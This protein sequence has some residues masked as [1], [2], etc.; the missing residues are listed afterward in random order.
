MIKVNRTSGNRAALDFLLEFFTNVS[1]H[2]LLDDAALDSDGPLA[3]VEAFVEGAGD[4][5]GHSLAL[6]GRE[7][8]QAE[9]S[10][11]NK[12]GRGCTVFE[13]NIISRF[14]NCDVFQMNSENKSGAVTR[15]FRVIMCEATRPTN[16]ALSMIQSSLDSQMSRAILHHRALLATNN[17]AQLPHSPPR[18]LFF[19]MALSHERSLHFCG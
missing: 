9:R 14:V 6:L 5:R 13:W 2:G 4:E 12:I 15:R 10:N 7:G 8:G 11:R 18:G 1:C 3:R 19:H 16:A 17:S